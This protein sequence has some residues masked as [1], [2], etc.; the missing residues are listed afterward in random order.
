MKISGLLA[1]LL[2]GTL[3]A[4]QDEPRPGLVGE[5]YSLEGEV[6]DFPSLPAGKKPAVRRVDKQ[7]NWDPTP[8][9]FAGTELV[10]HFYVRWSGLLRVPKEAKYTFYAESDDGSKLLIDGKEVVNNGGLHPME[11]KSGDVELKPGDH[12]IR[13]DLFENDGEAGIRISWEAPDLPREV[14]P[15]KSL[16]HRKDADLDK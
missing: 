8:E 11:E 4:R 1:A 7:V 12:E 5:Y 2:L 10:D 13:I 14:L 6:Q 16:F 3:P 15:E 9:K